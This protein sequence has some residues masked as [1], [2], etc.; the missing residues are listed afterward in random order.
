M[1][2]PETESDINF[3][4]TKLLWRRALRKFEDFRKLSKYTITSLF[5][6]LSVRGTH[7]ITRLDFANQ[8]RNLVHD[9]TE[10]EAL[11]LAKVLDCRHTGHVS[12][13]KLEVKIIITITNRKIKMKNSVV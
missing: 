1:E 12:V 3:I 6:L 4:K 8:L 10:D 7:K 9:I 13:Q 2:E 11:A 5:D